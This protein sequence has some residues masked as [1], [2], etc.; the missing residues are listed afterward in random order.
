MFPECGWLEEGKNNPS[1][2]GSRHR[3]SIRR[4]LDIA[5]LELCDS[6][7]TAVRKKVRRALKSEDPI[8]RYWGLQFVLPGEIG[9]VLL[10]SNCLVWFRM[11]W[12][13][14]QAGLSLQ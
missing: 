3:S 7:N 5:D 11:K 9:L 4:Y 13:M 6:E 12:H 10:H 1:L 8:E 14:L 2:Y